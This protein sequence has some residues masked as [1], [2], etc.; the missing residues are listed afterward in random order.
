MGAGRHD[1]SSLITPLRKAARRPQS[2]Y[3]LIAV[4]SGAE[5][6]GA[7]DT[8][9]ASRENLRT[10]GRSVDPEKCRIHFPTP[11]H[12][13]ELAGAVATGSKCAFGLVPELDVVRENGYLACSVIKTPFVFELLNMLVCAT[14]FTADKS[15]LCATVSGTPSARRSPQ[16]RGEFSFAL[17]ILNKLR[18]IGESGHLSSIDL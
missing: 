17:P 18:G 14:T 3:I 1:Q 7:E 5:M 15:A 2:D 16:N 8:F 13:A 6:L 11:H 10:A 4:L 12:L 9:A